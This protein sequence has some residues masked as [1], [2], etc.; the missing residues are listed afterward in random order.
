MLASIDL[1]H[2]T[3]SHLENTAKA[4]WV[5]SGILYAMKNLAVLSIE[6]AY[7][8]MFQIAEAA[9]QMSPS[10]A[11]VSRVRVYGT[12]ESMVCASW[13][14]RRRALIAL[15]VAIPQRRNWRALYSDASRQMCLAPSDSKGI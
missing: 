2:C 10:I 3:L 14:L 9:E 12:P 1:Q 15:S 11:R 6:S 5:T 7:M 8:P 4:V 13:R